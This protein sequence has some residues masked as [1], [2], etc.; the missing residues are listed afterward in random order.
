MASEM[1]CIQILAPYCAYNGY[2]NRFRTAA[3]IIRNLCLCIIID[4]IFWV[5]TGM[6]LNV[7][8]TEHFPAQATS[9]VTVLRFGKCSRL[10]ISLTRTKM[11]HR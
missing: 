10:E 8:T 9:G 5:F 1:V 11:V 4:D 6:H 2:V 7:S 3:N